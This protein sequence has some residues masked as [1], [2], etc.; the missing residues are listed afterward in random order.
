M[1]AAERTGPLMSDHDSDD[2]HGDD[3]HGKTIATED[4]R[5]WDGSGEDAE[6][7]STCIVGTMPGT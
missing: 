1:D 6:S 3:R 5:P 7:R 4:Q 2:R